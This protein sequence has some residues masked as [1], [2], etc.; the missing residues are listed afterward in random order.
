MPKTP[1][2]SLPTSSLTH[3]PLLLSLPLPSPREHHGYLPIVALV[4]L[5]LRSSQRTLYLFY[6][7]LSG[8]TVQPHL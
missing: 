2:P 1:T 7:F 3:S 6:N 8:F 4:G 5:E